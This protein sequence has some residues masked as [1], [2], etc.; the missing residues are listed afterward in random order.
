ME[1]VAL[2]TLCKRLAVTKFPNLAA[3]FTQTRACQ[4]SA[5]FPHTECPTRARLRSSRSREELFFFKKKRKKKIDFRAS[6]GTQ[7]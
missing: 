5:G 6:L 7:W 1:N 4:T 3:V 2:G